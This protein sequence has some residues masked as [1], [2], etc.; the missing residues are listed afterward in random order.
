MD[1]CLLCS[2]RNPATL[3]CGHVFCFSCIDDWTEVNNMCPICWIPITSISTVEIESN[4]SSEAGFHPL[5]SSN[6]SP[7][8]EATDPLDDPS[9]E[10]EDEESNSDSDSATESSEYSL[11]SDNTISA[12]DGGNNLDTG[13][14]KKRVK[15][16]AK[17]KSTYSTSPPKFRKVKEVNENDKAVSYTFICLACEK[18]FKRRGDLTRHLLIHEDKRTFACETCGKAF[19]RKGDLTRHMT[20]HQAG[21]KGFVC[22]VEGCGKSFTLRNNLTRHRRTHH[23]NIFQKKNNNTKNNNTKEENNDDANGNVSFA[24]PECKRK[25]SQKTDMQRHLLIHSDE[26]PFTCDVCKVGFRQKVHLRTHCKTKTHLEAETRLLKKKKKDTRPNAKS[27]RKAS[28][29]STVT[30]TSS[31]LSSSSSSITSTTSRG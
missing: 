1:K 21:T 7:P 8:I 30:S 13:R 16:K 9:E 26:R 23:G 20:S 3:N 15:R 29:T 5:Q 31:S 12:E 17:A 2:S 14:P 11:D 27:S 4:P 28:F 22:E 6:V 25:F 18:P 19:R 10:E 24:C